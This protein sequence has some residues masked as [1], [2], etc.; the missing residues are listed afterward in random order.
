MP[1]SFGFCNYTLSLNHL[2]SIVDNTD[3]LLV[4]KKVPFAE[5]VHYFFE[6]LIKFSTLIKVLLSFIFTI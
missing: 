2:V 6:W 5:I 3:C 1:F 4:A